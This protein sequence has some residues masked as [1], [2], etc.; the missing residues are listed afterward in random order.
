MRQAYF[1]SD[2]NMFFRQ[3]CDTRNTGDFIIL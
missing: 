2:K 1:E 3:F